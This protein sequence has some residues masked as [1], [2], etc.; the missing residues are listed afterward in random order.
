MN[1]PRNRAEIVIIGS[2]ITAAAV[3]RSA[4][5]ENRRR[6]HQGRVIVLEARNLCS[7]ATGRSGGQIQGSPHE[8]FDDLQKSVGPARAAAMIRF[9]ISQIQELRELCEIESWDI[10]EFR[11]IETVDFYLTDDECRAAFEKVRVV[12]KHVPELGIKAWC[13]E[14]AR[15]LF[16]A[17]KNVKGAVSYPAATMSPYRFVNCVWECLL[18]RYPTSLS[19]MTDTAALSIE[20]PITNRY[21]YEVVTTRGTFECDHVVHATDAFAGE[22]VPGLR[23]KLTGVLRAMMALTPSVQFSTILST[24]RS[25]VVSYGS[26]LDVATQRPRLHKLPGDIILGGGFS[27]SEEQG[28]SMIGV[29][30]DSRLDPLPVAHLRGIL[31]TVFDNH[32]GEESYGWRTKSSWSGTMGVTGDLLPFVGRLDKGLTSRSPHHLYNSPGVVEPGEWISAGYGGQGLGL[33]WLCGTALGIMIGGTQ[34]N[35][36]PAYPGRPA[37]PMRQWFPVGLEPTAKRLEEA[38]LSNIVHRFF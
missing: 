10:A 26:G 25:W 6:N 2:G 11:E 17:N 32:Q 38:N 29:Y 7:G 13:A 23:G 31:P 24:A 15:T 18:T 30:D 37:G 8:Y 1:P 34:N 22:L 20:T 35:A 9:Q 14:D 33:A 36:V 5:I 27:R 12:K 3:A 4:L 28:A 19:I 16:G 21:A